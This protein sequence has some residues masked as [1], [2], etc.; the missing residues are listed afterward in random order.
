MCTCETMVSLNQLV[1][2]LM[3]LCT[4]ASYREIGQS[5]KAKVAYEKALEQQ[6]GSDQ[7]YTS[8][9]ILAKDG[10]NVSISLS[11]HFDQ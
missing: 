5:G 4:G 9:A 8:L 7:L 3:A 10:G 11:Y 2:A 1:R 6:P